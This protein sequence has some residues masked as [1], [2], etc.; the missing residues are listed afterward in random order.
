MALTLKHYNYES[1]ISI[2]ETIQ[3]HYHHFNYHYY[4]NMR[5]TALKIQNLV[6]ECNK[7]GTAQF[8]APVW[9][10]ICKRG[11][12]YCDFWYFGYW[13]FRFWDSCIL[14]RNIM[15]FQTLG[16]CFQDGQRPRTPILNCRIFIDFVEFEMPIKIDTVKVRK[17]F[18]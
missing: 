9:L 14:V 13:H 18:F 4:K 10:N 6:L 17:F 16:S 8:G 2:S 7:P 15:H 3:D 12:M 5:S 1:D 11:E